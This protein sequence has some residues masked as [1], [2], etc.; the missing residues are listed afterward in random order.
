MHAGDERR[1]TNK[2]DEGRPARIKTGGLSSG[3]G[4]PV[5]IVIVYGLQY[6]AGMTF[7]EYLVI[8]IA[9]IVGS[10]TTWIMLCARDAHHLF[11]EFVVAR[12]KGDKGRIVRRKGPY[13]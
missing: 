8:A 7:P 6:W 3:V 1:S 12:R 2:R 10:I 4:A 9:A 11:Y 5:A 13:K